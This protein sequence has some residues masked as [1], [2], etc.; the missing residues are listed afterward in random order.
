M[1][2]TFSNSSKRSEWK[3]NLVWL[4]IGRISIFKIVKSRKNCMSGLWIKEHRLR[5]RKF[6]SYRIQGFVKNFGKF[7]CT[8]QSGLVTLTFSINNGNNLE[9]KFNAC[10]SIGGN[11]IFPNSLKSDWIIEYVIYIAFNI[12]GNLLLIKFFSRK[13]ELYLDFSIFL[14][15]FDD[16][17]P[18][19]VLSVKFLNFL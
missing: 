10:F 4:S 17:N 13:N 9:W 6:W 3:S 15:N 14:W 1:W 11:A 12:K 8:H 5:I 16:F 2:F 19:I 18:R 7:V